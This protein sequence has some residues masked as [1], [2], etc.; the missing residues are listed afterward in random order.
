MSGSENK[1]G[2]AASAGRVDGDYDELI[3]G[4]NVYKIVPV[5]EALGPRALTSQVID[6][7]NYDGTHGP[8]PTHDVPVNKDALVAWQRLRRPFSLVFKTAPDATAPEK[9]FFQAIQPDPTSTL[10]E[11]RVQFN[12]HPV[13]TVIEYSIYCAVTNTMIDPSVIIVDPRVA[14][15]VLVKK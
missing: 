1:S 7:G 5:L 8:K 15:F 11:A 14:T 4:S 9:V 13:G 6:V 2:S 3:V 10:W 12:G